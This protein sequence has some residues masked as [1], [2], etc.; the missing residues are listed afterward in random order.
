VIAGRDYSV[1]KDDLAKSAFPK[2]KVRVIKGRGRLEPEQGHYA[3]VALL[4]FTQTTKGH[5]TIENAF[6]W[7]PCLLDIAGKNQD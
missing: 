2:G 6:A 4:F 1:F 3:E 7:S 5:G